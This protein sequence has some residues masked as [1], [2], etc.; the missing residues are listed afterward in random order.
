MRK[1]VVLQKVHAGET[2]GYEITKCLKYLG[3]DDIVE[4]ILISKYFQEE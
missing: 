3:F 1:G 2:K 4:G